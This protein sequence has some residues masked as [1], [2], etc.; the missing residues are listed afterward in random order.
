[1]RWPSNYIFNIF[2]KH[3]KNNQFN[4]VG[5]KVGSK[6]FIT[7]QFLNKMDRTNF[8]EREYWDRLL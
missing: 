7:I 4:L 1:M 5:L 8:C 6:K 3:D 2:F